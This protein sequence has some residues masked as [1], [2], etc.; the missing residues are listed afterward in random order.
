MFS[1]HWAGTEWAVL[2]TG[3]GQQAKV[4]AQ[5]VNFEAFEQER[6]VG[7]VPV[8]PYLAWGVSGSHQGLEVHQVARVAGRGKGDGQGRQAEMAVVRVG[9][10]AVT[11]I[12]GEVV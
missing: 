11:G 6:I 2:A 10:Q 7:A 8:I 1:L 4:K 3:F 12:P 5:V 9:N